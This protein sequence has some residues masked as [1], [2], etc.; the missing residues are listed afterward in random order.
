MNEAQKIQTVLALVHREVDRLIEVVIRHEADLAATQARLSCCREL[1]EEGRA[2]MTCAV[3]H[4]ENA[5]HRLTSSVKSARV[6][7][8]EMRAVYQFTKIFENCT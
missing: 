7:L 3:D 4:N 5:I 2:G 8:D 1:A 6:S